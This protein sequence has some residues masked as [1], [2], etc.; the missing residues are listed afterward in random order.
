MAYTVTQMVTLV[1]RKM[2]NKMMNAKRK[3]ALSIG[4]RKSTVQEGFRRI[5]F[6]KIS[7]E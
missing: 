1:K 7:M 6:D 4:I 3:V 2:T 5:D